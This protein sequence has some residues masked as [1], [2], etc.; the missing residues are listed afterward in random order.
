MRDTTTVRITIRK[1]HAHRF[2]FRLG[3]APHEIN[4]GPNGLTG[5]VFRE[6]E[7]PACHEFQFDG[8][9]FTGSHGE[10]EGF[11][12]HR[13]CGDGEVSLEIYCDRQARLYVVVDE[14]T[15]LP[16]RHSAR[17]VEEFLDL[18]RS[19]RKRMAA[20]VAKSPT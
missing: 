2:L 7:H 3:H 15:G 14:A 13:M 16:N 17:A 6:W 9:P 8:I 4:G 11:E 5:L 19:A 20:G 10:G 12:P 1:D 18:E